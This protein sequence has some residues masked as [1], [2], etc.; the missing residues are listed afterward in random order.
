[1]RKLKFLL[2]CFLST[3]FA[4]SNANEVDPNNTI[5]TKHLMVN[6]KPFLMLGAQLRTDFFLQLDKKSP[7][8]LAPYFELAANM[9]ILVVQ[10]PVAWKDVEAEKDIYNTELVEKYIELCDKYQLKLEILWFGSY[11]CGYSVEGYIPDYV[12]N[13]TSTYP[14]LKPSAAFEG[15]LGKHYYLK[16]NTP[17]LVERESKAL[18]QMMDAIYHYDNN[19]GQKHTVIGIQVENEPD[20]LATRH[21]QEHG[22]TPEQLWRDLISMLDQLGQVVK[23]SAY[24]CYTRVNQT[25]TYS[26]YMERSAEIAATAGIDYVGLDPYENNM[27]GIDSKLRRLRKIKD[28]YG[29]IA[30]NGG[31]YANN[32]LLTLKAISLGCGYEIFEVITTPQPLFGRLDITRS[33]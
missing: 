29:H 32:D 8:E 4:C 24:D 10:V 15:W 9:N 18:K 5:V 31:E 13:N 12:I 25:T 28:N 2:Y 30:E 11:M 1:M 7:E 6:G 16:P 22:Y 26:D 27:L 14:D 3:L 21:N 33:L 17:A 19:H 20:M 23:N